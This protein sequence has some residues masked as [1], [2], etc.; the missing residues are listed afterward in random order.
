MSWALQWKFVYKKKV[1]SFLS[2]NRWRYITHEWLKAQWMWLYCNPS[3]KFHHSG[4][5]LRVSSYSVKIVY[6][7]PDLQGASRGEEWSNGLYPHWVSSGPVFKK[8]HKIPHCLIFCL[9][10]DGSTPY[11]GSLFDMDCDLHNTEMLSVR[12]LRFLS[13]SAS[14]VFNQRDFQGASTKEERSL[15]T[16][17]ASATKLPNF[18]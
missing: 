6:D 1:L 9:S 8:T 13:Y 10:L 16:K 4:W 2:F 3:L 18:K 5:R 17:I 15:G 7:Q 12:V 11:M 14:T